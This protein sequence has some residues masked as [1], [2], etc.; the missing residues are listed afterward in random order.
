MA[1]TYG[2]NDAAGDLA[3]M[4]KLITGCTKTKHK[5]SMTQFDSMNHTLAFQFPSHREFSLVCFV[6]RG[7]G[8]RLEDHHANVDLVIPLTKCN[9]FTL[10]AMSRSHEDQL[11]RTR[12][13]APERTAHLC[14][15]T[16]SVVVYLFNLTF[17]IKRPS[18][19]LLL[20]DWSPPAGGTLKD[21]SRCRSAWRSGAWAASFW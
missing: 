12:S 4:P 8:S 20:P 3:N 19:V 1:R 9:H 6:D 17:A 15:R 11:S 18:E 2:F 16:M 5:V 10:P 13:R 7:S 21:S 14:V